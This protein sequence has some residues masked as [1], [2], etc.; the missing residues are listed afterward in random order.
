MKE[1]IDIL[2]G[3]LD[4]LKELTDFLCNSLDKGKK[5]DAEVLR[6]TFLNPSIQKAEDELQDLCLINEITEN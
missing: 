6:T 3:R 4:C 5:I 1:K 2:T